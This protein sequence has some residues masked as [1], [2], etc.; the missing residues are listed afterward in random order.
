MRHLQHIVA[1]AESAGFRMDEL[2]AEGGLD[3][4]RLA[5]SEGLVPVSSIEAMLAV[6]SARYPDPLMG[7]RL[8][9]DIQPATFGAV[10]YL[11][12]AC[13]TLGDVLEVATRYNGL[14]SNIGK[15]SLAHA[16]GLV[17]VRWECT[18]VSA[19]L[20]AQI[21][22]YVIGAFVAMTRLLLPEKPELVRSVHFAHAAPAE[23][24]LA[25]EYFSL[26]RCPVYFDK[27][28]SCFVL[29][30]AALK[31]KLHHGDAFI[32][33][34]LE[35]HAQTLLRQKEQAVTLADE[36]RHLIAAMV[37]DGVP[38]KD[39]VAAQLGMSARSLHRRLTELGSSYRELLDQVRLDLAQSRLLRDGEPI[40]RIAG[41][42]G[43]R[44]HQAFLRWYKHSTGETPGTYRQKHG[45]EMP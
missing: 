15:T 40:S 17:Q 45:G 3:K 11:M 14:L 10:G 39:A 28:V 31:E 38:A 27:P 2:L 29:D 25:R 36:V 12:Q 4:A 33:D 43:F 8:A 9:G 6:V 32:K 16:P 37:I 30:N 24:R 44:S 18:G 5:D 23:V 34:L 7:L 1:R 20:K 26:F 21:T 41:Q 22:D 13:T 42:L 35:R 19:A